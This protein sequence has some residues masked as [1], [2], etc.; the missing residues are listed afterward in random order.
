MFFTQRHFLFVPHDDNIL[1][2]QRGLANFEQI[3]IQANEGSPKVKVWHNDYKG[4]EGIVIYFHGNS[5]RLSNNSNTFKILEDQGYGVFAMTYRGYGG[6]EGSPSEKGIFTDSQALIDFI[7]ETE[8]TKN[9]SVIG[10][11]L[12][13]GVATHLAATNELDSI[14]LI[15]P[16]TSVADVAADIYWFFP[17][18][19]LIW[20]RFDSLAIADQIDERVMIL[21]GDKDTVVPIRFGKKLFEAIKSEKVFITLEGKGHIGLNFGSLIRNIKDW[22]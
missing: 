18:Q 13:T 14:V 19:W 5:G 20:D 8:D 1:P 12:G 11:S 6:S 17:T 3:W 21:H 2:A 15:S 4:K 16:Y 10:R 22:I 7:A 9:I